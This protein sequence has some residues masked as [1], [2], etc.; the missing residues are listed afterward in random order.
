MITGEE[1]CTERKGTASTT[2]S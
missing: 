2:H 1:A